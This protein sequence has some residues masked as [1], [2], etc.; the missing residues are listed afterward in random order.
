[1]SLTQVGSSITRGLLDIATAAS[2]YEMCDG[3]ELE[4]SASKMD[5]RFVPDEMEFDRK[6]VS[7]A[8]DVPAAYSALKYVF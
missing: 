6:P 4:L 2:I 8:T 7:E 5:L 1:M 3:I